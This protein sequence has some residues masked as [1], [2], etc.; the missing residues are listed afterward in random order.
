MRGMAT[1]IFCLYGK[2]TNFCKTSLTGLAINLDLVPFMMKILSFE[3]FKGISNRHPF[4]ILLSNN[5]HFMKLRRKGNIF[6]SDDCPIS[7]RT[8]TIFKANA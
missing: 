5:N 3:D 8:K 1:T 7:K 6:Q 4:F 2:A